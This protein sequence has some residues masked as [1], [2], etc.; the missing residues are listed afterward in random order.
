MRARFFSVL[1]VFGLSAAL[2]ACGQD[3]VTAVSQMPGVTSASGSTSG[4]AGGG[5]GGGGA[6]DAG[7]GGVGG[8]GGGTGGAGGSIDKAAN[9]ASEFGGALTAPYGRIDGTVLA[10]VKPSDTDCPFPNDD[11][12][13]LQVMMGGAAY[14][15]VVNVKSD[16]G[17]PRVLFMNVD[18]A[19]PTPA[20]A[21]GWHTGVQ[22]DYA[23]SLGAD[24]EAFTPYELTEISNLIADQIELGQ[25]VSVYAHTS[26][27]H[28]AHKVH[29]NGGIND[30]GAIVLDPTG[31]N[32]RWLLFHFDDQVF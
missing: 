15:M 8:S 10:V 21:E 30:D 12:V 28:S 25:P 16:Y 11:H 20:W 18:A 22:L 32:P 27:G 1:V 3:G 31:A 9:C 23:I 4:A 29:R 13:V 5:T 14:R 2:V 6:G 7:G 24:S 17:D 26:G 19:L